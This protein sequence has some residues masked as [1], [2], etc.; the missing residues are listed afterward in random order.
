MLTGRVPF[1]APIPDGVLAKHLQEAPVPLS[2]FRREIPSVL[3]LRFKQALGK[4]PDQRQRHVGDVV[5]EHRCE[6]AAD[7]LLAEQARQRRSVIR[8]SAAMVESRLPRLHARPAEGEPLGRGWRVGAAV[9]L[10]AVVSIGAIR[11][12]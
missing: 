7:E 12:F 2:R 5:N 1:S 9:A 4:E 10:L 6:L 3:E 8:K 11:M